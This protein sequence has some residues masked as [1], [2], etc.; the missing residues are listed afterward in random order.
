MFPGLAIDLFVILWPGPLFLVHSAGVISDSAYVDL[1]LFLA[2]CS[3]LLVA[4]SVAL[5][6]VGIWRREST[7]GLRTSQFFVALSGFAI[8][9]WAVVAIFGVVVEVQA[10]TDCGINYRPN[11]WNCTLGNATVYGN[12]YIV[13]SL[14]VSFIALISGLWSLMSLDEYSLRPCRK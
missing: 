5:I 11:L 12:S 10:T 14:V 4:V 6:L 13:P 2:E 3:G 7:M 9:A 8:F 1:W